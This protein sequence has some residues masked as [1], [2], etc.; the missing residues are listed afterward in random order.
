MRS[1]W[2]KAVC[3]GQRQMQSKLN[4]CGCFVPVDPL[5][6][7]SPTPQEHGIKATDIKKLTENGYHTVEG[8]AHATKKVCFSFLASV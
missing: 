7:A 6:P 4:V 8:V 2:H 5:C 1:L 3:L